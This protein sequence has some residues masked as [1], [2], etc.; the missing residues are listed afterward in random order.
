MKFIK[1]FKILSFED[2]EPYGTIKIA[3]NVIT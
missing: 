1:I 3:L 2:A